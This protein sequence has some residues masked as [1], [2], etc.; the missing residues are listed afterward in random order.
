ME[1][2]RP[3]PSLL[4]T[5]RGS[6]WPRSATAGH[7]CFEEGALTQLTRD[8]NLATLLVERGQLTPEE[9][10]HFENSNIILQ[11][12]GT[13]ETVDVDLR[14]VE[15]ARGDVILLCSDG[16]WGPSTTTISPTR[17]SRL[18]TAGRR[19]RRSSRSRSRAGARTT[20]RA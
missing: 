6:S 4:R 19:P 3:R 13:Q 20:L 17:S 18:T 16:L 12:L 2:G 5:G 14:S 9:A 11:A 1:W 10:R 7:T 8:Q 15:L